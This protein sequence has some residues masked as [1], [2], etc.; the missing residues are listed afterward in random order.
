MAEPTPEVAR[1]DE[2]R[3]DDQVAIDPHARVALL[4]SECEDPLAELARLVE[5]RP[6]QVEARESAQDRVVLAELLAALEQLERPG[7]RIGDLG[8]VAASRE[9][10]PGEAHP[11]ADLLP[12]E[13]GGRRRPGQDREQVRRELDRVVIPAA[14]LVEDEE[15]VSKLRELA[16]VRLANPVAPGE[17]EVADVGGHGEHGLIAPGSAQ[18]AT[19]SRGKVGVVGR[20]GAADERTRPAVVEPLGR[21]L[22]DRLEHYQARLAARHIGLSDEALLEE[23]RER[24]HHV[25]VATHLLVCRGRDRLH[26]REVRVG[27][28][29]EDL[30]QALLPGIEELVAPFDRRPQRLLPLGQVAGRAPEQLEPASEPITQRFRREQPQAGRSELDRERQAVEPTADVAD[31]GRVVVVE[32]KVGTDCPGSIDEELDRF[33][34]SRAARP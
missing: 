9:E 23:R 14:G 32:L 11:E 27:K 30:E 33:D 24:F 15:A 31:R 6:E 34:S 12:D 1:E 18:V 20:V 19:Q 26:R 7:V 13:L 25:D 10:R 16:E 28:D 3:S 2:R 21:I 5:L 17:A 4:L 8:G 29:R 22:P